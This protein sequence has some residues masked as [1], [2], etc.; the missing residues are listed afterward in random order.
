MVLKCL[1]CDF[2]EPEGIT[3]LWAPPPAGQL[4]RGV[5]CGLGAGQGSCISSTVSPG[6]P[7]KKKKTVYSWL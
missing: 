4:K 1:N 5:Q 3:T 2:C 6:K 7:K